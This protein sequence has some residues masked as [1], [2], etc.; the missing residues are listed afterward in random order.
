MRESAFRIPHST[1]A[2]G[3]RQAGGFQ[4]TIGHVQA[5]LSAFGDSEALGQCATIALHF[6]IQQGGKL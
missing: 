2:D 4:M 6:N 5:H 1:I 3:K